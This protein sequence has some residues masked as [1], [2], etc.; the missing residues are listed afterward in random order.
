MSAAAVDQFV[1]QYIH[2]VEQLEILLL[3]RREP[4]PW[5]AQQISSE[6]RTNV[7]AAK[8]RL[9]ALLAANVIGPAAIADAFIFTPPTPETAKLI[10]ELAQAYQAR[11]VA[12]ITLIYSKP[13]SDLKALSDA[14]RLRPQ[15]PP[16]APPAPPPSQEKP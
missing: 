15:Q 12:I 2:S 5:T 8:M 9:G 1:L 13:Q 7:D 11:R 4:R 6:L 3:M 10:G 14:F 16:P